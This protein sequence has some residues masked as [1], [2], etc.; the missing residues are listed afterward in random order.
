MWSF[1]MLP[2]ILLYFVFV[3]HWMWH[4]WLRISGCGYLWLCY[5]SCSFFKKKDYFFLNSDKFW[6]ML[7]CIYAWLFVSICISQSSLFS[8]TKCLFFLFYFPTFFS[9]PCVHYGPYSLFRH[10][11]SAILWSNKP[12]S[13]YNLSAFVC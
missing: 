4:P 12:V 13:I 7:V 2:L 9:F 10:A 6:F 1:V 5:F 11:S 8:A 3:I